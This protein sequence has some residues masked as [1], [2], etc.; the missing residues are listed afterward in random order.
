[1]RNEVVRDYNSV[2][3][4]KK[5]RGGGKIACW[6]IAIVSIGLVIFLTIKYVI[7]R[8]K[9]SSYDVSIVGGSVY[10]VSVLKSTDVVSLEQAYPS[11]VAVGSS[12]Y[13]W[14]EDNISYLLALI[15]PT[16]DMAKS[17]I[18]SNQNSNFDLSI[19]VLRLPTIRYNLPEYTEQEKNAVVDCTNYIFGLVNKLYNMTIS[20]QLDNVSAISSASTIN[21]YKGDLLAYNV[22]LENILKTKPNDDVT[23]LL[24]QS[25]KACNILEK[26]VNDLLTNSDVDNKMKYTLCE[27][28]YSVYNYY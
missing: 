25:V 14:S 24:E 19:E 7:P 2:F 13:I 3:E 1:M 9:Q 12:G 11:A 6:L 28:I 26:L 16:E 22:R 21:S 10:A 23:H 27:Y 17:V 8:I 18:A 20:L 5:Y 15:Y 4:I